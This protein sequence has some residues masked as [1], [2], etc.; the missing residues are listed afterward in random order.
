MIPP[1]QTKYVQPLDV[2]INKPFKAAMHRAYTEFQISNGN[3]KTPTHENIIEFVYNT[4]YQPDI[5]KEDIIRNSLKICGISNDLDG[6]EDNLFFWPDDIEP[7]NDV[8][9][10]MPKDDYSDGDEEQESDEDME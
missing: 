5:I 3:T 9:N 10:E 4:W 8:V 7:E 1:G 2:S 6:S